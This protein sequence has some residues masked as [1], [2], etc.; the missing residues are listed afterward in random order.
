MQF[1]YYIYVFLLIAF[2][3]IKAKSQ[4]ESLF[5]SDGYAIA[6]IDYGECNTIYL[7]DGTPVAFVQ[8]DGCNFCVYGFNG[9]FIGWLT[10]GIIFDRQGYPLAVKRGVA[11]MRLQKE[12]IKETK[13]EKPEIMH[14]K[15]V[16]PSILPEFK[17]SWSIL[18]FKM[19]LLSG[20]ELA[21][22]I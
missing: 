7:Y 1:K 3:P 21:N 18:N 9:L 22:N 2:N 5:N 17:D 10:D 6:Y 4:Q 20:R 16:C 15:L 8:N 11:M 12:P 19:I 13:K 14:I